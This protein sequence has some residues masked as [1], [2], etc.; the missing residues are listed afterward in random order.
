MRKTS[1]G[2]AATALALATMGST[3]LGGTALASPIGTQPTTCFGWTFVGGK[4]VP[5]TSPG[6]TSSATSTNGTGSSSSSSGTSTPGKT[7]NNCIPASSCTQSATGIG[8]KG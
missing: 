1:I 8:G 2:I 3:L 6:C 4:I 5:T 7:T